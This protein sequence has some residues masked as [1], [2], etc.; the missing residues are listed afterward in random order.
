MAQRIYDSLLAHEKKEMAA[1]ACLIGPHK[2][3]LLVDING[4][5]A[6]YYGSQGQTRTACLSLKLAEREILFDD[7]GEYPVL[8][9]D[10]V[11]SELDPVRRDFVLNKIT[12]GQ[13]MITCC[14]ENL[15]H[16][17]GRTFHI[18]NG[19]VISQTDEKA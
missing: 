5:P 6:R 19:Q 15:L 9:L 8:L 14:E 4:S 16:N 13:V 11:L 7:S 3:D 12:G 17:E 10:D 18:D 1:H 2:D